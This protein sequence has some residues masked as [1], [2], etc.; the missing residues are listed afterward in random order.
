VSAQP[1]PPVNPSPPS[2]ARKEAKQHQASA[3]KSEEG[4]TGASEARQNGG[5]LANKPLPPPGVPMTR[6]DRLRADGASFTAVPRQ[7]QASAWVIG[8]EWGG[9]A[10]LMALVLAFGWTT[11][12]PTPRARPPVLPAPAWARRR[13]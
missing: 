5:D 3:A 13:R 10:A 9:G 2:G 6:R 11:V 4:S 8:L 7:A 1:T 12:R